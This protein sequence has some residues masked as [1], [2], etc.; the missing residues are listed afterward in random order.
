MLLIKSNGFSVVNLY[1]FHA[2]D[3]A[4]TGQ[5]V[6]CLTV[7]RASRYLNEEK[8]PENLAFLMHTSPAVFSDHCIEMTK[9]RSVEVPEEDKQKPH[10]I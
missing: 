1:L 8:N 2:I 3:L 9:Y 7:H 4:V 6:V 5:K 10:R